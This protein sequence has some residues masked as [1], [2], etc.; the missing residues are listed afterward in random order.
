[1]FYSL[2]NDQVMIQRKGKKITDHWQGR[3]MYIYVCKLSMCVL[4]CICLYIYAHTHNIHTFLSSTQN[5][6]VSQVVLL[7]LQKQRI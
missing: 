7:C 2:I 5:N 4:I 6:T 1:M 3:R